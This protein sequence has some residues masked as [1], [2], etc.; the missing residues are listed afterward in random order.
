MIASLAL[1]LAFNPSN[2]AGAY[3]PVSAD[4]V[5]ITQDA[6][7][8]RT[9]KM[10]RATC[11][12]LA[13]AFNGKATPRLLLAMAINESDLRP[14]VIARVSEHVS[15][16][17]LGGVRCVERDGV[18][19]NG[20]A[21][22]YTPTQLLDPVINIDLMNAVLRGKGYNLQAYNGGT[23]EHGYRARIEA[24]LRALDGEAVPVQSRRVRKLI[25]Q[26]TAAVAVQ[27]PL[28]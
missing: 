2:I 10:T 18:C 22:G 16:R 27:P 1:L 14:H 6:I 24:L 11:V 4:L 12:K 8:W 21:R 17:G 19:A 7:R 20:P 3:L 9:A 25:Q 5:C 26:I 13:D 15:D 28:S 23:K